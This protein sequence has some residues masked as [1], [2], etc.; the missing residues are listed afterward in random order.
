MCNTVLRAT[1]M[2][3][4][5]ARINTLYIPFTRLNT[6]HAKEGHAAIKAHGVSGCFS[7]QW[8]W[9]KACRGRDGSFSFVSESCPP[10]QRGPR[11]GLEGSG[12]TSSHPRQGARVALTASPRCPATSSPASRA[13]KPTPLTQVFASAAERNE[14]FCALLEGLCYR[15]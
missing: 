1:F 12:G 5:E 14:R 8:T 10:H 3:A 4:A 9:P 2:L 13:H 11:R 6:L 15:H 7:K